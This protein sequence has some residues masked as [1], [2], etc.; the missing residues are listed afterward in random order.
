MI[1]YFD[2]LMPNQKPIPL[3]FENPDEITSTDLKK[4]I[5]GKIGWT[6]DEQSLIVAGNEWPDGLKY[7]QFLESNPNHPKLSE[8]GR[9]FIIRVPKDIVENIQK[10]YRELS[11]KVAREISAM[12]RC[13][14]QALDHPNTELYWNSL[15]KQKRK[16]LL[17][18]GVLSK[19][20]EQETEVGKEFVQMNYEELPKI[21]AHQIYLMTTDPRALHP[22]QA[23]WNSLSKKQRTA[24]LNE[25]ELIDVLNE[26]YA[27]QKEAEKRAAE[28]LMQKGHEHFVEM[29]YTEL[30]V[31][32]KCEISII[33]H[34][35]RRALKGPNDTEYY[36][37][38]LLTREQRKN[39]LQ[40]PKLRDVLSGILAQQTEAY[41]RVIEEFTNKTFDELPKEL[42]CEISTYTRKDRY[43]ISK[44]LRTGEYWNGFS[45]EQRRKLL[46]EYEINL[47]LNTIIEQTQTSKTMTI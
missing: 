26:A 17:Q 11:I 38:S 24:L 6:I 43:A 21:L 32:L 9:I 39:L 14:R 35:V 3:D 41:G 29:S 5:E 34:E 20:Q 42:A 44:N 13:D 36:W 16:N 1:L 4:R 27:Q 40:T 30:P 10:S 31:N 22:Q 23:L 19:I 45:K 2:T 28:E 33:T 47:I 15:S 12:T 18:G 7:S 8:L 37:D 25:F 46:S